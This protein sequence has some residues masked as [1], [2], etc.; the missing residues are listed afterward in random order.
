MIGPAASRIH[1]QI[2]GKQSKNIRHIY[3]LSVHITNKYAGVSVAQF[4][5]DEAARG[6]EATH[7]IGYVLHVVRGPYTIGQATIFPPRTQ[8]KVYAAKIWTVRM[9]CLVL[10]IALQAVRR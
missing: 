2:D 8:R 7:C 9:L 5:G 4:A 1:R 6:I 3:L 10:R